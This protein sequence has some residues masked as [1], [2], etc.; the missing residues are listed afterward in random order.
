M[1]CAFS[2][3]HVLIPCTICL[4]FL[5]LLNVISAPLPPYHFPVHMWSCPYL[6]NSSYPQFSCVCI[7]CRVQGG[8]PSVRQGRRW[9]DHLQPVWGCHA[10]PWTEPCQRWG[11]QGPGQPQGWGWEAKNILLSCN[12]H[13]V[14]RLETQ[15]F[16]SCNSNLTPSVLYC[17]LQLKYSGSVWFFLSFCRDEQ[18]DA[19]LWAVLAH[20]P[21]DR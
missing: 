2:W 8:I 4:A 18:Q 9:E 13:V 20:V 1:T 16:F 15:T 3:L 10:G 12:V 19:R 7:S 6:C 5:C 17:M 14:S 11:A 21:G